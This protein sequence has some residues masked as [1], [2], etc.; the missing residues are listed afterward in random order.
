[1]NHLGTRFLRWGLAALG[2]S[3]L[4]LGGTAMSQS[5]PKKKKEKVTIDFVT[6]PP[7][8]RAKVVHGRKTFGY[9]PFTLEV[10]KDS[11]FRDIRVT[12]EGYLTLNTRFHTFKDHKRTLKLTKVEDVHTLLGYKHLPQD[13]EVPPAKEQLDA[14][15]T[16]ASGTNS[17]SPPSGGAAKEQPQPPQ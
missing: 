11:G 4:V 3:T 13:A 17:T 7:Q 5:G 14:G 15:V 1:M 10:E 9:T 12:A 8:I 2:V 16:E 6:Y